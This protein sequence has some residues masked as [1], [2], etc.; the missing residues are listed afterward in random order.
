M[1]DR[2]ESAVLTFVR[3]PVPI[4]TAGALVW[5]VA[6]FIQKWDP[7]AYPDLRTVF[8]LRG[9][10]VYVAAVAV[11]VALFYLHITFDV[12]RRL[13]LGIYVRYAETH[14]PPPPGM[15]LVPAGWFRFRLADTRTKLHGYFID[16]SPV[17]NQQYGEFVAA[18]GHAPPPPWTDGRCPDDKARHPVT[19]VDWEDARAYCRWRSTVLGHEVR[20]PTEQEWEK[21]ARGPFG[22][23]Y[24]WGRR[25]DARRCNIGQGPS[26][27]TTRVDAFPAGVS[28]YGCFDMC[29]NTWEWTET[30]FADDIAVLKGGSF[31]FD[32]EFAPVWMRYHDPKT[33]KWPDLGFRCA[34]SV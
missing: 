5:A 4:G 7:R 28:P 15:V 19:D 20:L 21:A 22:L 2:L 27:D 31:Y 29:G 12:V 3:I 11:A 18:T 30:P 14:R 13:A 25:F 24:P 32:E 17:T 6:T 33:D 34:V 8:M 10:Q 16:R 26:G 9:M 1:E 23:R